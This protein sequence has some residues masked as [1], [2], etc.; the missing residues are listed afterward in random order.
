MSL[1]HSSLGSTTTAVTVDKVVLA[2]KQLDG[3]WEIVLKFG[4]FKVYKVILDL[5]T[6]SDGNQQR[7]LFQALKD[8]L[9]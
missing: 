8:T 2:L 4:V 9:Q 7:R 3:N 1:L 5:L 6:K